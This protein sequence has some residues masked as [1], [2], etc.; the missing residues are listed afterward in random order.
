MAI[1]RQRSDASARNA[2]IWSRLRRSLTQLEADQVAEQVEWASSHATPMSQCSIGERVCVEGLVRAV[3][4]RPLNS[5]P[6]VE[7]DLFDGTSSVTVAW[8][9]RRKLP[10]I[11]PGRRMVVHGRLAGSDVHP[12]I[13]NPR[14]ELRPGVE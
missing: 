6:T 4:L 3:T 8:I 7:I 1:T 11:T 14:Y 13:F 5:N 2:G 10:G 9:G 12:V